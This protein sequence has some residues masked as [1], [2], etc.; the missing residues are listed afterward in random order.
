MQLH[1]VTGVEHGKEIKFVVA[2][3]KHDTAL[4]NI[5]P[6]IGAQV[7]QNS[8]RNAGN[9]SAEHHK[10]ASR[11]LWPEHKIVNE[12]GAK[13]DVNVSADLDN[14]NCLVS[15]NQMDDSINSLIESFQALIAIVASLEIIHRGIWNSFSAKGGLGF[16][17]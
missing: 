15:R 9:S 8:S 4:K 14:T 5:R 2:A 7:C 12:D 6:C 3:E 17:K 10:S 13:Y 16:A 1:S 11:S